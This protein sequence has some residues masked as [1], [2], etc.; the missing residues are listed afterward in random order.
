[1]QIDNQLSNRLNLRIV[2]VYPEIILQ[3]LDTSNDTMFYL[4]FNY[5]VSLNT[6]TDV[7]ISV[8]KLSNTAHAN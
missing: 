5:Y 7:N 3:P 2:G 6:L 8:N 1:M 4:H